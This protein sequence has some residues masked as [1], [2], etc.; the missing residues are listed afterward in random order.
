MHET[1]KAR[2]IAKESRLILFFIIFTFKIFD[3]DTKISISQEKNII[4]HYSLETRIFSKN[5]L[6]N[7]RK[8]QKTKVKLDNIKQ[9]TEQFV[10]NYLEKQLPIH[11]VYHNIQHTKEVVEYCK[12]ICKE[13]NIS[14]KDSDILEIAAWLHDIGYVQDPDNHERAGIIIAKE[15]LT[16][17]IVD[18]ET[19]KKVKSYIEATKIPH[20]P[21]C[22]LAEI[23]C[24]ADTFHFGETRF[25]SR[26]MKLKHEWELQRK[27]FLDLKS[28]LAGSIMFLETHNYFTAFCTKNLEDGKQKNIS[29]LIEL[30]QKLIDY[31]Y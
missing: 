24:D 11:F 17:L 23:M 7:S 29:Y 31:G 22:D 2:I 5:D 13:Q 12:L 21:K 26:S 4:L 28:F 19:I 1:R 27:V 10:T 20:N 18:Q 3:K 16:T 8:A 14:K 6:S 30:E 15:F 25:T 9:K